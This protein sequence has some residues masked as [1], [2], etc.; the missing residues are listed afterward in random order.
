MPK[1]ISNSMVHIFVSGLVLL[2]GLIFRVKHFLDNRSLWMDEAALAQVVIGRTPN[3]LLGYVGHTSHFPPSPAGFLLLSKWS[4]I[5]FG[6]HEMALRLCPLLCSTLALIA[7]YFLLKSISCAPMTR[8]ICLSLMAVCEPMVFYAADFRPYSLD[9][10]VSVSLLWSA[11][12]VLQQKYSTLAIFIFSLAGAIFVWFS[13]PSILMIAGLSIAIGVVILSN[14]NYNRIPIL[15]LSSLIWLNSYGWFYSLSYELIHSK[16][17]KS[18]VVGMFMPWSKGIWESVDWMIKS[19]EN[20][21][22]YFFDTPFP[23]AILLVLMCG[24]VWSVRRNKC[25]SALLIIPIVVAVVAALLHIY[26]FW[27]RRILFLLPMVIIL[28]GMGIEFFVQQ[29]SRIGRVMGIALFVFVLIPPLKT[30]AHYMVKPRQVEEMRPLMEYFASHS[31]EQDAVFMNI[32]AQYAF[33]YYHGLVGL[34]S[35]SEFVI[36][37]I[38]ATNNSEPSGYVFNVSYDYHLYDAAGFLVWVQ[39]GPDIYEKLLQQRPR[40]DW[41][42]RTWLFLSKSLTPAQRR[43]ILGKFHEWGQE[44]DVQKAPGVSLHLFD[45]SGGKG[46]S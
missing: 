20:M 6:P 31:R 46:E 36:K 37:I 30:N 25:Y 28:I 12:N 3:E 18:Q 2:I 23:V 8:L 41:N 9:V 11:N 13:F 17:Y 14:R 29:F 42:P 43:F 26:P 10:L 24:M 33:G 15:V 4:V 38:A 7:F 22:A 34:G 21:L 16:R 35:N 40:L 32:A 5:A 45:L 1:T 27:Q 19:I 44:L 39:I